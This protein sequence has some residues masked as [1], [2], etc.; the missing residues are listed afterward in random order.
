MTK[1]DGALGNKIARAASSGRSD[2]IRSRPKSS[3]RPS[4][5][6]TAPPSSGDSAGLAPRKHGVVATS[7]PSDH[8]VVQRDVVPTEPPTPQAFVTRLA[9]HPQVIHSRVAAAF[10]IE[11][12]LESL[13][14]V[15]HVLQAHDR[16][17]CDVRGRG[18][19][20]RDEPH[21]GPLLRGSLLMDGE[22]TVVGRGIEPAAAFVVPG[23]VGGNSALADRA[24]LRVQRVSH[25][26]RCLCH[27]TRDLAA[28]ALRRR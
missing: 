24:L 11:A 8:E 18:E 17:D 25:A 5:R 23:I 27:L 6:F 26:R 20:G 22:A 15:E 28:I 10:P 12:G 16:R 4:G 1:S 2:R 14:V 19:A 3:T 21:R 13:G 7:T 9:E